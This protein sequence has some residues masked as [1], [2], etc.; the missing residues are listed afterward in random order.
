M[1]APPNWGMGCASNSP[2]ISEQF[3]S[4]QVWSAIFPDYF[5]LTHRPR[6]PRKAV[7]PLH[8]AGIDRE[9]L[10]D[11]THARAPRRRPGLPNARLSEAN[12]GC[13][14]RAWAALGPS[15]H[16]PLLVRLALHRKPSRVRYMSFTPTDAKSPSSPKCKAGRPLTAQTCEQRPNAPQQMASLFDHLVGARD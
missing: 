4:R 13:F 9:P 14:P 16:S 1:L 2:S 15:S 10:G 11:L 7:D 3:R 8:G 12:R 6:L 5:R